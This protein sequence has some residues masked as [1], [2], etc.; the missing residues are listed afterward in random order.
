MYVPKKKYEKYVTV[1][2][3]CCYVQSYAQF[4]KPKHKIYNRKYYILHYEPFHSFI[5]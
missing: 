5:S 1:G 3:N 2:M 4:L